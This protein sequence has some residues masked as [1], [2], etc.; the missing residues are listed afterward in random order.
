M[1]RFDD[2]E[3]ILVVFCLAALVVAAPL[4]SFWMPRMRLPLASEQAIGILGSEIP[5][6]CLGLLPPAMLELFNMRL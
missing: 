5:W 1:P 3:E 6:R 4:P 2:A